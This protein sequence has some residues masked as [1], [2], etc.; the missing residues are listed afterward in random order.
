[1]FH[2]VLGLYS[3]SS[4]THT[5]AYDSDTSAFDLKIQI[6]YYLNPCHRGMSKAPI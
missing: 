1:M 4:A 6:S 5:G 3:L 2:F